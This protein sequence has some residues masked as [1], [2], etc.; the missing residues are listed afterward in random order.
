MDN[1]R[2]SLMYRWVIDGHTKL[3]VP[4]PARVLQAEAELY[5]LADDPWEKE[6]LAKLESPT[7]QSLRARLD[8]WWK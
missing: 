3:I 4:N 1:P 5:D 6:N 2:S 8:A 7:V